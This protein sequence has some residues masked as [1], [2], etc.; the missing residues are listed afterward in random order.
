MSIFSLSLLFLSPIIGFATYLLLQESRDPLKGFHDNFQKALVTQ[1]DSLESQRYNSERKSRNR[2]INSVF[3]GG[4]L[5]L[6]IGGASFK[7]T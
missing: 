1:N 4:L 3:A 7:E 5:I 2:L 6:F